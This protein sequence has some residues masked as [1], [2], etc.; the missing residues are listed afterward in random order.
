MHPGCTPCAALPTAIVH[1]FTGVLLKRGIHPKVVQSILGHA[2]FGITMDLYSHL[3]DG[4][5]GEAA[6]ALDGL[7]GSA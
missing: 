2:R 1:D 7:L 4:A 6:A 3:M 5:H